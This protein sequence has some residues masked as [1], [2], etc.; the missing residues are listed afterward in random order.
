MAS[1]KWKQRSWNMWLDMRSS[2][3][4]MNA[5]NWVAANEA[6]LKRGKSFIHSSRMKQWRKKCKSRM[7]PLTFP[8]EREWTRDEVNFVTVARKKTSFWMSELNCLSEF[9]A[10][11]PISGP[12]V[13]CSFTTVG[14]GI[15]NHRIL[16]K[17]TF[18][19]V[20]RISFIFASQMF[21]KK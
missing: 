9:L 5:Q 3:G 20:L 1:Q 4:R 21:W 8:R 2:R 6:R 13:R 7:N 10:A 16:L 12:M 17:G 14:A 11:S 19:K 15:K 18:K